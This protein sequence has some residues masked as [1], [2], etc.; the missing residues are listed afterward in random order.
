MPSFHVLAVF[1]PAALLV[2]ISPGANNLLAMRNGM[3]FSAT[4]AVVALGGRVVAFAL[5]VGLVVAGLATVVAGSRTIFEVV[6]WAGV[7]YLL[8]L[9]ARTLRGSRE[10][11]DDAD[12]PGPRP[13]AVGRRRRALARQE[14]LVAA[15]N[16]KALLLFTAFVPQFVEPAEAAAPQLL[17]LGGLYIAI[18]FVAACGWAVAGSGIGSAGLSARARRRLEQVAGGV[19]VGLAGWLATAQR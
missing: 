9:G 10:V 16:P 13:V 15:A 8:Y 19:F 2:A 12:G 11:Q 7:A 1:V 14:L 6:K 3:R 5:M 4:D 18:E 17:V